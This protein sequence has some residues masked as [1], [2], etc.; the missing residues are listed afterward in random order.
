MYSLYISSLFIAEET[1]WPH[2]TVTLSSHVSNSDSRGLIFP[3]PFVECVPLGA[4][5][6]YYFNPTSPFR[7][8]ELKKDSQLFLG[9]RTSMDASYITAR[10]F[11]APT[12]S[13]LDTTELLHL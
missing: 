13:H 3:S 2:G 4:F 10:E 12:R 11:S 8:F 1:G 9:S 5:S 7:Y 6:M